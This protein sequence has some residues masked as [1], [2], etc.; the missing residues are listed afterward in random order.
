M[1]LAQDTTV[2][3]E[4]RNSLGA[5]TATSQNEAVALMAI[6]KDVANGTTVGLRCT[7]QAGENLQVEDVK[8][9]ATQ[10]QSVVGP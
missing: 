4:A 1:R 7:E 8:L 5:N 10:V 3:D 6:V 2:L 9:T